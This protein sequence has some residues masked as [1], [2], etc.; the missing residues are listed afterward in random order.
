MFDPSRLITRCAGVALT[1]VVVLGPGGC[2]SDAPPPDMLQP[3][4]APNP[5]PRYLRG[6]I[7]RNVTHPSRCESAVTS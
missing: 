3:E 5:L 6:T 2:S 1:G 7:R 4:V